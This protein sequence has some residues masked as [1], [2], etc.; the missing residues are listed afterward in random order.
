MTPAELGMTVAEV[1]TAMVDAEA[2]FPI[3]DLYDELY[4]V[5][6]VASLEDT[7]RATKKELKNAI[8]ASRALSIKAGMPPRYDLFH[9]VFNY[10]RIRLD[11]SIG[12]YSVLLP[13][14]MRSY[15][16]IIPL[17]HYIGVL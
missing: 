11:R 9:N 15:T 6:T 16:T 14:W 10:V 2:A 12:A 5:V 4:R 17:Y 8:N 7:S 3:A 13:Q 1:Q